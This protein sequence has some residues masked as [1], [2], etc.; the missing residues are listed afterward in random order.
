LFNY[1]PEDLQVRS[2]MAVP[3]LIGERI[4]GFILLCSNR[5]GFS[6]DDRRL[7]MTL[8][9][10]AGSRLANAHAVALSQKESARYSLM[11]ELVKEASGKTM[12]E[13]LDLCW[14]EAERS[15]GTT[16]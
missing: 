13:A 16:R 3:M 10:R 4:G 1:M 9:H 12:Q 5:A 11:N 8:T 15:S 14:R 2:A 6:D 7:A